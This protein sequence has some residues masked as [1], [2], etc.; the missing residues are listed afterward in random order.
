MSRRHQKPAAPPP[1]LLHS[2]APEHSTLRFQIE[3]AWRRRWVRI[4]LLAS[5]ATSVLLAAY[6]IW[7]PGE[8]HAKDYPLP[9]YSDTRFLN[10]GADAHYVGTKAC[11]ECHRGNH[12]SYLLTAHSRAF[13][14][15]DPAG[16]PADGV[17]THQ[18]SGRTYRVY[19]RNGELRHE[20]IVHAPDGAEIARVD[21]PIRYRIGSG[22]FARTYLVEVDGFLH[23]S[24]ITWY[25]AKKQW[26]MSPG[27]DEAVHPSFERPIAAGCLSCHTGRVEAGETAHGPKLIEK[28]IGCE[29]CHGPGSRHVEL[30]KSGTAAPA[31]DYTIV[32]PGKLPRAGLEAVCAACHL[33]GTARVYLRGR[34]VGDYRPGMPLDD[35]CTDYRLD[36]GAEEMTVVGHMEQL[37]RS[38]CYQKSKDM[39]C[40][41]CHDP[42][43]REI[44]KDRPAYYRN[45]CLSCHAVAGCKLDEPQR[46]KQEPADNCAACHMPRGDTDI[47][48][49]AFTHHRIGIH[50]NKPASQTKRVPDLVPSSDVSRLPL[51][52]QQRNLGLAYLQA[53]RQPELSQYKGIFADRART[54]LEAVQG[55]GLREADT[56]GALAD[57]YLQV[58]PA[59]SQMYAQQVMQAENASPEVRAGAL[60]LLAACE[61]KNH[62]ARQA[63]GHLKQ[64]TALR[65]S[66]EDWALL[67]MAHRLQKEPSAAATAL[68]HALSIRPDLPAIHLQLAEVYRQLGNDARA[69]EHEEKARFLQ[70]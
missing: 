58:D 50:K 14:D 24:P 15:L 3:A 52:D 42:H 56:A 31:E 20:E 7:G 60:I 48:H 27:Y 44:P 16:E 5:A 18:R 22:D 49:I 39:S 54:I 55:A 10:T 19:R 65:R 35:Y 59:R 64:V 9:A 40:L 69:R 13:A 32:Q 63:L 38:A 17:F 53:A 45:Q 12:Q 43:A 41:S 37:R 68:E 57:L 2:T 62:D 8:P 70:R 33:M 11:A 1:P 30:R 26:G 47:P 61:L 67:G 51:V 36:S 29:S 46:R 25:A 34:K 4:F 6:L 66:S 23:E 28:V 21:V